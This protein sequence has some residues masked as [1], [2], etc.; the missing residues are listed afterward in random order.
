MFQSCGYWEELKTDMKNA[1][2]AALRYVLRAKYSIGNTELI[3]QR[4]G[5][6]AS[7]GSRQRLAGIQ[8]DRGVAG[9]T[10]RE[11]SLQRAPF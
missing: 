2:D 9:A 5:Q 10:D 8:S 11:A 7:Q 3:V 4:L 6:K 1:G